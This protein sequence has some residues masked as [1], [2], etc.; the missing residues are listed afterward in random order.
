MVYER[1]VSIEGRFEAE[2]RPAGWLQNDRGDIFI[3]KDGWKALDRAPESDFF[4]RP[5]RNW[6]RRADAGIS[7][8]LD[9]SFCI[10]AHRRRI[11]VSRNAQS[12]SRP[13]AFADYP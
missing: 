9:A 12:L 8:P 11:Y 4:E 1:P 7:K 13:R 3:V 10:A 2:G 6:W 5:R